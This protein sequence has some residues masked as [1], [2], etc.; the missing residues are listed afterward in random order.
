MRI[1]EC[2]NTSTRISTLLLCVL[3]FPFSMAAQSPPPD[4]FIT[5]QWTM[6]DGLP[7]SS[8]NYILQSRDG[9]LWLAT[10]GGLVRF[11]GESFT[12]F[13]R[14]NTP[15]IPSDRMLNLFEDRNGSIWCSTERGVVR[16]TNGRFESFTIVDETH[17]YSPL[18]YIED[19]RG[20]LWISANGKPYRF[21]DSTFKEVP[22][23]RDPVIVRKA[24]NDPRGVWMAHERR[25]LRTIG[26]SVVLVEDLIGT[27]SNN[28]QDAIEYPK[29]SGQVWLATTG[30]GVVRYHNGTIRRYGPSDGL[31]SPYT[32]YWYVDR[33]DRLWTTG[34]NGISWLD[35]DRFKPLRTVKGE[36][37]REINVII[38][39][40]EGNYWTGSPSLGLIRLRPSYIT[41]LDRKSGLMEEKMLSMT[42]LK[43][44]RTVFGTNCGGL[45]EWDGSKSVY[46]SLNSSLVNLC[47]WSVFEDSRRRLWVGSRV[48]ERYDAGWKTKH[49]FDSSDG[50]YGVD[51]FSML[52]DAK[53]RVWIGCLN[54]L[55]VYDGTRFRHYSKSDG[56]LGVDVRALYEDQDGTLW[57]GTTNGLFTMKDDVFTLVG[58]RDAEDEGRSSSDIY[59]R[60]IYEDSSGTMWFGTYGEGLFRMNDGKVVNIT[61][62]DGLYD[63]IISH[64]IEDD[65]GNFWMGCNRGIMRVAKQALNDVADR[66]QRISRSMVIS[67]SDGMNSQETNGGFQPSAIKDEQGRIMFPTVQGVAIVDTRS[68]LPNTIVPPVK[69]EKVF[70]GGEA[71]NADAEIVLPY[72]SATIEIHYASLSYV[73]RTKVRYRYSLFEDDEEIPWVEAGG[74]SKAYFTTIQPGSWIFRVI[75]SNNDGIWN[76]HGATLRITI[77]PPW[78]M[79]WWFRTLVVLFFVIS[80]PSAYYLRVTQLEKEKKVQLRFAEQLIESQEQERRRIAAD[81]HDGLGQQIL[82]IKNRVEMALNVVQDPAAMTEQL[83]EIAESARSS[84]NDV[85][86]ISHGL[87]PVHLEQF[88]LRE[89]LL[90]LVEQV[91]QSSSIEWVSHVDEID[92]FI[93]RDQEI[94]FFRII[95]EGINNVLKHS[96]AA[97]ASVMI[98]LTEQGLTASLWDNGRGFDTE[99]ITSGLGLIGLR[100]RAKI[101]HGTCEVRSTPGEGTTVFITIPK[102]TS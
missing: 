44:G 16:Y 84:I 3:M 10:F 63:N 49:L 87:R 8:V 4:R 33:D 98:R 66:H 88:G 31:P 60:A 59:V 72:D 22:L 83:K 62:T 76:E 11:N 20:V 39:D 43:D 40:H 54:G 81:L 78:W 17:T 99:A 94:N 74:R 1:M 64:I 91:Q 100:E 50:F 96:G 30:D 53:G 15:G 86:T 101:M 80:G 68:I 25:L 21:S 6:D 29:G 9:Y 102:R 28:I 26:D 19:A 41:M 24:L 2:V 93:L 36:V 71:R 92:G 14:S 73:D 85:R 18:K 32:R 67:V 77:T 58:L 35:G 69:I 34:F 13:D 45:Y 51:I 7:Q 38:Q 75:G 47:T 46:S 90:H 65:G 82:I 56:L 79:T 12:T 89:T 95:Q 55:F 23:L 52:E 61:T 42:R 97:Q 27:L 70:V 48:L 37:D 5:E 57:I